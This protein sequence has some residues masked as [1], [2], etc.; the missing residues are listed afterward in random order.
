[1]SSTLVYTHSEKYNK[2][3]FVSLYDGHATEILVPGTDEVLLGDIYVGLVKN[4]VK[5][6]GAAFIEVKEGLPCYFEMDKKKMPIFIKQQSEGKLCQGDLVL[7]QVTKEAHKTKQPCVS[8]DIS[9]SSKYAVLTAGNS[10]ISMSSKLGEE[11]RS[12]LNEIAR[13][14]KNDEYGLIFRTNA[15]SAPKE[16]IIS[17]IEGL[18]KEYQAIKREAAHKSAFTL[19]KR[20][21]PDYIRSILGQY[22]SADVN[23]IIT[24]N[25]DVYEVMLEY[26]KENRPEYQSVLELYDD[27][28]VSLCRF[29]NIDAELDKAVSKKVWLKSGAYLVIEPTEAMTVIDVNSGKYDGRKKSDEAYL[30][31]NLV[32]AEEVARQLRLRN[33]SGICMIDFIDMASPMDKKQL[34]KELTDFTAKDP[35][36]TVVVDITKLGLVEVTRK[37]MKKSLAEQLL[38]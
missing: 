34:I 1:M 29:H 32:A 23:R 10:R 20:G 16:D 9:I 5:N 13:A 25:R 6:I 36:K 18:I 3:V 7:V 12:R 38:E 11:E 28:R 8:G 2:D 27:E 19:V 30:K 26:L 15:G 21:E 37:R 17:Q 4:I 33:I 31:I 22:D 24:D 35:V 14:Y